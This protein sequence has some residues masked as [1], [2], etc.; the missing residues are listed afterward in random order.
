MQLLG[1]S[2]QSEDQTQTCYMNFDCNIINNKLQQDVVQQE[3]RLKDNAANR[4]NNTNRIES[5]QDDSGTLS[6]SSN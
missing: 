3:Q 2:T 1:A 4:E 6:K 5:E